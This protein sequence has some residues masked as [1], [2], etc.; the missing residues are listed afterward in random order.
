MTQLTS[1]GKAR[2]VG[3]YK[4]QRQFSV[5]WH[6]RH[7]VRGTEFAV[8]EIVM[9]KVGKKLHNSLLSEIYILRKINQPNII[10]LHDMIE[11]SQCKTGTL[12]S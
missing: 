8:K 4:F 7:R 3:D 9:E 10:R 2:V 1:M 12:S 6:T 5:V 11:C